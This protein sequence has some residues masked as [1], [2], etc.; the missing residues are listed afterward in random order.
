M[1][2]FVRGLIGISALLGTA[3]LLTP[4]A[5]ALAQNGSGCAQCQPRVTTSY[6][7]R[8]VNRVVNSTRFKDVTRTNVVHH[9]NR[10]VTVTRIQPIH[11][12]NVVTRVHYRTVVQNSTQNVAQT[13]ML[14]AR[15]ITTSK[16]I[17]IGRPGCRCG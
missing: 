2:T 10:V 6:R 11:R 5:P 17:Q 1:N 16:T 4:V 3:V 8:T 12:V 13:R 9:V 14:P 7:Y 15:T